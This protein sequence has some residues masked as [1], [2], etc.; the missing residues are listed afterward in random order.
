MRVDVLV[1]EALQA[2]RRQQVAERLAWGPAWQD[3]GYVFTHEDGTPYHPG[4]DLCLV[5]AAVVAGRPSADQAA[6]SPSRGGDARARGGQEHRGDLG[7]AEA[8]VG[9]DPREIYAAVLPELLDEVSAAVVAMVPRKVLAAGA[10]ETGGPPLVPQGGAGT[11]ARV[12]LAASSQVK[13]GGAPGG[14]TLNQRIKSPL[15]CH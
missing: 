12:V 4:A 10:S 2:W 5:H 13:N 7:D 15:L 9:V 1:I 11:N 6:R 14:R 3:T 8:R